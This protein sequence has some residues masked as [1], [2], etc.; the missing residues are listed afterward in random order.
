M[1]QSLLSKLLE[2][3]INL[4]ESFGLELRLDVCE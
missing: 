4:D 1:D 3:I 2:V